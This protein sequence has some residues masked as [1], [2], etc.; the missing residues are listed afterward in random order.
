MN[1]NNPSPRVVALGESVGLDATLR[2]VRRAL[3]RAEFHAAE[4]LLMAAAPLAGDYAPFLNLAGIV[5]EVRGDKGRARKFY[6]RAIRADYTYEP[7]QQN[8][9][10]QYELRVFGRTVQPVALGGPA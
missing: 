4:A 5:W 2:A 1:S 6:C 10:R 8:M 7:A 3:L 9:R